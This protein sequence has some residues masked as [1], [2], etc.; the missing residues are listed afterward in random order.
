MTPLVH[1]ADESD[2]P[3][4]RIACSRKWVYPWT[5]P[6][7]LPEGVHDAEGFWYTFDIE[8]VTCAMCSSIGRVPRRG[9]GR[10]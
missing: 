7:D 5:Q 10:R 4:V 9:M 3:L 8:K 6:P 2:Q 1:F